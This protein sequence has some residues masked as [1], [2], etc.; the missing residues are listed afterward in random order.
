MQNLPPPPPGFTLD[1]APPAGGRPVFQELPPQPSPQTPA[2]A[3][4]DQIDV[5]E[6]EERR[7]RGGL[8]ADKFAEFKGQR[9]AIGAFRRSVD[10]ID[11]LFSQKLSG[12][13]KGGILGVGGD[14]NIGG[15]LPGVA[16]PDNVTFNDKADALIN[17][18]GP[19]MGMTGGE[20]NSK[21]ELEARFGP[22]LPRSSDTDEN[23]RI[24][25]DALRRMADEQEQKIAAMMGDQPESPGATNAEPQPPAIGDEAIYSGSVGRGVTV[26]DGSEFI[27][28]ADPALAGLNAQI[29][30]MMKSG[31]GARD[32]LGM[33]KEKG[34]PPA[35]VMPSVMRAIQWRK[36]NPTFQGDYSVDVET[37]LQKQGGMDRTMADLAFSPGGAAAVAAGNIVTGNRLDNLVPNGEQ[38]NLG[39]S[40][41]REAYPGASFTGDMLGSASLFAGARAA[42]AA[43]GRTGAPATGTFSPGAIGGDMAMGAHIASGADGTQMF[44]P[45]QAAMGALMGGLGGMAGR[46][47]INTTSRAISP[48]GG[49]LAPA[50]AEGVKPTMGQRM[51]GVV[52]RAEQAFASVPLVGGV[53]RSARNNAIEDWQA[54]A[55][56]QSLREIGTQ[57]P[58]GVKSGTQAHAYMQGQFNAAYNKARSGLTF[59]QDPEFV[60]DFRAIATEVASLAP[61]AQKRFASIV[62]MGE[63]KLRARGGVLAG[64]D[65]K[66][67][68]STIEK[69]I[70][71]IRKSPNG[72]YELADVL[73][74]LTIAMDSGARRHSTPE[75]VAAIDAADRGYVMA[76]LIEEAGRKPGGDVGEF[77]GK[78]LESAMRG[79][80]GLRSRRLL[81]GDMPMQDYA[82][83]GVRLGN[84]VAD[85]GTAERMATMGG[86]GALAHFIDP[87]LLTP[88]AANT[89]ANIPGGKQAL[90]VLISPNR[91]GLDPARRALLKRAH[92]GGLLAAPATQ[93]AVG[94]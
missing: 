64:D 43:A 45:E 83:A 73:E 32:F 15:Y 20:M 30:Q 57:L 36:Q 71:S 75:A 7:K 76:V 42:L 4:K 23:I 22:M 70:R 87:V 6:A 81:R 91:K 24:K 44:S 56:N 28:V 25:L 3:R 49:K 1:S 94:P 29:N 16:R 10:E 92:L 62:A 37:K 31:A 72:D 63:N 34:I 14:R 2:Q 13:D 21:A 90:N 80:S 12:P 47:V 74:E 77:T 17:V 84:T 52:N 48:S 82:A 54:G 93:A 8:S 26:D 55:F 79:D 27:N 69:R 68:A 50:Y 61:D 59:R 39:M 58:K 67:L 66:T 5:D 65:Y 86:M 78:Q 51:G 11:Q 18:L 60:N 33:L 46:G 88:W 53:Q 40:A 35:E 38:A 9:T 89:L 19:M 85:S 41:L